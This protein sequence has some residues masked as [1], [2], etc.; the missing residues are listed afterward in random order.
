M[1]MLAKIG[2]QLSLLFCLAFCPTAAVA[3]TATFQGFLLPG[4][5]DPPIPI[6]VNFE[7]AYG[8][9]SGS[10]KTLPPLSGEGRI[11]SGRK[12][13]NGCNLT[14]HLGHGVRLRLDGHCRATTIDGKYRLYFADGR[15]LNG[16]FRLQSVNLDKGK[17]GSGENEPSEPLPATTTVCLK[18]NSMCLAGCPRGEHSSEL[19]CANACTRKLAACKRKVNQSFERP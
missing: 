9:I 13:R 4:S 7:E 15:R 16:T 6:T 3:F 12:E 14:S 18:A 2:P 8:N 1:A 19:L 10:V 5:F 11:T 17:K